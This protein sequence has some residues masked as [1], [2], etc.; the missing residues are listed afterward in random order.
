MSAKN[1]KLKE[2]RRAIRQAG[3]DPKDSI[4]ERHG[5]RIEVGAY[6]GRA[7]YINAKERA[8]SD[9]QE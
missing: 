1:R 3:M 5:D 2:I 9:D 8:F 6:C 7:R 4:H